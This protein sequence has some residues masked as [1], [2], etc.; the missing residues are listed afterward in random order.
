MKKKPAIELHGERIFLRP[1]RP[2]DFG[3]YAALMKASR[4][5]F[6]GLVGNFK[7]RKQF[8]DFI[9]RNDRDDAYGFLICRR[10]DGVIVGSMGLFNIVRLNAK[11]A[12]VG[13]S[14]GAPH[15]RQGYATEALQLILKFAFKKL[16]LHRVEASIQ[17][18]NAPSIAVVKRA[19]FSCEGCS[20]RLVK[21]GGRWRDHE[22][23]AILAEDWRGR[24]R[25]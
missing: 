21:I 3:E 12:F 11:T 2:A 13:Y 4:A 14:I 15:M 9:R 19:G 20:R 23:W 8:N 18:H 17:P 10:A 16:R 24:R 25:K 22:R 6:R 5:A 7:S 1:F